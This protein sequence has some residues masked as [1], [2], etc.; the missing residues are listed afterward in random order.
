M[1]LAGIVTGQLFSAET[2][3]GLIPTWQLVLILLAVLLSVVDERFN[4]EKRIVESHAVFYGL[5]IALLLLGIEL[6]S[7]T[8]K[9]LPFVYFQF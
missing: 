1:R 6:L 2:G 5:V 7:Q 3:L 9:T 8:D 4:L